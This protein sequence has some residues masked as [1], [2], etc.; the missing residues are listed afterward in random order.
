MDLNPWD[1]LI[2]SFALNQLRIIGLWFLSIRATFF[3][4]YRPIQ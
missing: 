3:I 4:G 1:F 2:V